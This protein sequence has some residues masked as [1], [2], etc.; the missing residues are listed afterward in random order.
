MMEV[1]RGMEQRRSADRSQEEE[2]K[3]SEVCEEYTPTVD[4]NAS[5]N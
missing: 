2:I 1:N 4:Q 3:K 5:P